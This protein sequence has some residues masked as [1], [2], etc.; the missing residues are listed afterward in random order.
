MVKHFLCKAELKNVNV[1]TA[2][3]HLS[4]AQALRV[5]FDQQNETENEHNDAEYGEQNQVIVQNRLETGEDD[6]NHWYDHQPHLGQWTH[7][8]SPGTERAEEMAFSNRLTAATGSAT[9]MM[10]LAK[11]SWSRSMT[12]PMLAERLKLLEVC[13]PRFA[14]SPD[15]PQE[16]TT[17]YPVYDRELTVGDLR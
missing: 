15:L 9:S 2:M 11:C 3:D 4:P 10:S 16:P 8:T 5:P 7:L 14:V 17:S 6:N 1:E 12:M 13:D